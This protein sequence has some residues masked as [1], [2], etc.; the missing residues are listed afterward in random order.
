MEKWLLVHDVW[1]LRGA[2]T[3]GVA[4]MGECAAGCKRGEE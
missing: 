1:V 2:K 4:K 3:T